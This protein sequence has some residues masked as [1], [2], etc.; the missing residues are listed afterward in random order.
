MLTT[1]EFDTQ[2]HQLLK[3]DHFGTVSKEFDSI[4]QQWLT[5]RD[6]RSAPWWTRS[7][8]RYLAKREANA[9][10]LLNIPDYIPELLYW[11]NGILLR[12]WI[13]G[14]PMQ[15]AKPTHAVYFNSGLTLLRELHQNNIAHNDLSKETNWL[16]TPDGKPALV[17]FQL[18]RYSKSRNKWF[19]HCA[20]EDIRYLL[21]HKRGFCPDAMTQRELAI[22]STPGLASR[23]W[24]QTG[25]RVYM[26]VTRKIFHWQDREGAYDRNA[27][28]K[29]D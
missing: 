12:S 7:I 26:F 8:A 14:K 22:V 21:K 13:A 19:R 2:K 24:K 6:T 3:T 23:V 29:N 4:S 1:F 11:Q 28:N 20:R 5:C 10:R 18:A 25:K 17:D 15:L 9:L 16:V 27:N